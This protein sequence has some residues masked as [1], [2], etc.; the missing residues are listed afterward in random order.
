MFEVIM[1]K[2]NVVTND[3]KTN[4]IS[5]TALLF[6]FGFVKP[7]CIYLGLKVNRSFEVVKL[8]FFENST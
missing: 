5:I 7:Y 1:S 2:C 4:I 6:L 3:C 8:F